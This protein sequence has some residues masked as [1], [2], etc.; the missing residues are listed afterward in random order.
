MKNTTCVLILE[1]MIYL[2]QMDKEQ[3]QV[4]QLALI[5][6]TSATTLEQIENGCGTITEVNKMLMNE[7]LL[8]F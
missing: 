5:L 4:H 2:L 1:E 8:A 7:L 6:F 3:T